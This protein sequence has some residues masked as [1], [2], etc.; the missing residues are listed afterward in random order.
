MR[1]K[2]KRK[3]WGRGIIAQS[4]RAAINELNTG[5]Q[6]F[7]GKDP[8]EFSAVRKATAKLNQAI[9][10]FD[11]YQMNRKRLRSTLEREIN[12]LSQ[13][14]VQVMNLPITQ[15]EKYSASE[16]PND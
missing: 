8:P 9:E 4:I 11:I 10:Y 2:T 14:L 1:Q 5:V 13:L 6:N 16:Q 12:H 3:T 15:E 7:D